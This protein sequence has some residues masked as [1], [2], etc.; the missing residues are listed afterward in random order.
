MAHPAAA[1][2]RD[3]SVLLV[4]DIQER[5]LPAIDGGTEVV[6]HAGRIIRAAEVLGVPVL[7]TEQ[8]PKGLGPTVEPIRGTLDPAAVFEKLTFSACGAEGLLE[9]LRGL[10]RGQVVVAG[11]ESHICVQQTVLELLAEGLD[12]YLAADA[13]GS[14]RASDRAVALDRARQ[15]GA[16]VTTTE[17]VMFEWLAVAGTDEF[18]AVSRLVREL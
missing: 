7:A 8:Y 15:A 16:V 4:V 5:L 3:S 17:A 12:V 11:I 9:R 1:T 2:S 18:K 14:R 13:V 10:G 6:R